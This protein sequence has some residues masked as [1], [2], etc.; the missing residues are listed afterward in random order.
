MHQITPLPWIPHVTRDD[1]EMIQ[2]QT[3]VLGLTQSKCLQYELLALRGMLL[4]TKIPSCPSFLSTENEDFALLPHFQSAELLSSQ[5]KW[6]FN[7][8]QNLTYMLSVTCC[9]YC[10]M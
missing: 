9:N 3:P 6:K 1:K 10:S 8:I 2:N 4:S 5:L 7:C